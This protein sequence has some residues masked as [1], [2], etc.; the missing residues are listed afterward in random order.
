MACDPFKLWAAFE[1]ARERA[2]LW[3]LGLPETE[4]SARLALQFPQLEK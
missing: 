2:R 1:R 4:I 3:K